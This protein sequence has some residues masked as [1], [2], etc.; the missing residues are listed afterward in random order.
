MAW[1]DT[2]DPQ[3]HLDWG[4]CHEAA[5]DL[6]LALEAFLAAEPDAWMHVTLSEYE[7]HPY[8][9]RDQEP[10]HCDVP[11][12]ALPRREQRE[13]LP[14]HEQPYGGFRPSPTEPDRP[15][16]RRPRR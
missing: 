3:G 2:S 5:T 15:R 9:I 10:Q 11:L 6:T 7:R 16:A 4:K 1:I 13:E 8:L 12:F 14:A